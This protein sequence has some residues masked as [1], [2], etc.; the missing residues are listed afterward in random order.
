MSG[1]FV[2]YTR[3]MIRNPLLGRKQMAVEIVHPDEAN[4]S[5]A[6][7]REK[8]ATIF[9]TK[10]EAISVFGLHSKFGGGRSSGFALVYDNLDV[11]KQYDQKMFLKR[12][13]LVGNRAK[14]RKQLKDIKGRVN[15]VRGTAK[16]AAANA[17]GKKK[18]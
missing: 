7:I 10:A 6:A 13:G 4:V 11:R 12:D 9:K 5:K 2:L 14:T 15:K 3:K 18:K 8:L 16:F 17:G 1:K